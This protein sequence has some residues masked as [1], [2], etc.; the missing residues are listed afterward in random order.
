MAATVRNRDGK[1]SDLIRSLGICIVHSALNLGD[2]TSMAGTPIT[3]QRCRGAEVTEQIEANVVKTNQYQSTPSIGIG[4]LPDWVVYRGNLELRGKRPCKKLSG[5]Q[6]QHATEACMR[7]KYTPS[8]S[9]T[10]ICRLSYPFSIRTTTQD[11]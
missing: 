2:V 9:N 10:F 6:I 4:C 1:G 11:L 7:V 3:D 5:T 8:G